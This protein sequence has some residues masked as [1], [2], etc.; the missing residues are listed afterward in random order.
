MLMIDYMKKVKRLGMVAVVDSQDHAVKVF[1]EQ[2]LI[3][4]VP[5]CFDEWYGFD[6]LYLDGHRDKKTKKLFDLTKVFA[7]TPAL[8]RLGFSL[9]NGGD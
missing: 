5:I 6:L 8:A 9:E 4:E 2:H 7:S 1:T 3:A